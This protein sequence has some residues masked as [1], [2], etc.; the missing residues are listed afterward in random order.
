MHPSEQ[1]EIQRSRRIRRTSLISVF[2]LVILALIAVGIYLV[3]FVILSPM[4]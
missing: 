1:A 4:I 3:A 2:T